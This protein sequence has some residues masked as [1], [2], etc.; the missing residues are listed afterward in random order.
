MVF[1]EVTFCYTSAKY[2]E[3]FKIP[4]LLLLEMI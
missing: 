4:F 2:E 3:N 1:M